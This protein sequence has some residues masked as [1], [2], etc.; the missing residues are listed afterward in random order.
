M[1][2]ITRCFLLRTWLPTHFCSI[3]ALHNVTIS[4]GLLQQS[5]TPKWH[6]HFLGG[7]PW[8]EVF[9]QLPHL[10]GEKH[11]GL[12]PF[13]DISNL[14]HSATWNCSM[15]AG[16][17]EGGLLSRVFFSRYV[18][19]M[20]K[21]SRHVELVFYAHDTGIIATSCKQALFI[22]YL[23]ACFNILGHCLRNWSSPSRVSKK[24]GKVVQSVIP[25]FHFEI[26]IS[27][28]FEK[29]QIFSM[30]P[31]YDVTRSVRSAKW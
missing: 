11:I 8:N 7:R 28:A 18:I 29:F 24:L 23:E 26:S 22:G 31:S 21:S 9:L 16:L 2:V 20:A 10:P 14:L 1:G 4:I 17:A 30:A 12:P 25:P 6:T 3:S 19:D 13:T 5:P 15:L 27:S